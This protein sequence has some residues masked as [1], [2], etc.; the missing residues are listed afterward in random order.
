[1]VMNIS[2]A[3]RS[4]TATTTPYLLWVAAI[5]EVLTSHGVRG[6]WLREPAQ[7]GRFIRYYHAGEQAWMA[8]DALYQFWVGTQRAEREAHDGRGALRS[9]YRTHTEVRHG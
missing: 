7:R 2:P 5:E 9:A 6:E 8:A 3:Y 1:M 4:A